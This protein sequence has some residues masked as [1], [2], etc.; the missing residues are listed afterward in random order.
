MTQS[1]QPA[2]KLPGSFGQPFIGEASAL[3][4]QQELFYWQRFQRYAGPFKTRIMSRKVAIL[5]GPEANQLVLKDE[6]DKFSSRLG[7][8]ILEP[9]LGEGLLL[10]DGEK[11]ARTRKLMYPAFHG[12]ALPHYFDLV[13]NTVENFLDGGENR[14]PILVIEEFRHLTLLIACRLLLGAG[15]DGEVKQLVSYFSE[16]VAGIRTIVRWNIPFTKF[17]RALRARWKLEAFLRSIIEQ[18]RSQAH[19]G[20]DILGLLLGATDE[21][22]NKLSDPEIIAQILNLL[23]A[24]H[25]TTAKLVT[26]TLFELS[27]HP[28]WLEKLR[29]EQTEVLQGNFLTF[30][31]LK[32]LRQMGYV[33]KE[34]E[35]L[36]PPIYSIPRGV[37]EDVEY[38]GYLIPQGWYV[39]L[40]PLLTHRLSELYSEPNC[41]DPSRFAPPREED[42]RHPFA[43]I[44][45]GGGTHKCLGRELASLEVKI[46]LSIL[47]RRYQW[48]FTIDRSTVM[49]V[50]QANKIERQM[51]AKVVKIR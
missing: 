10:Q 11:H 7:W 9:L 17:G 14:G 18:R 47:L 49:P 27:F 3:F 15:A 23:F 50:C 16:I 39:V 43:L 40:S 45:F 6:A 38:G 22:G 13:H 26:W 2:D 35:R 48:S 29:Q 37:I 1:I 30:S 46:I 20:R 5:V 4:R 51:W 12:A 8:S 24:A 36:H 34:I 21:A 19:E 32:H 33:L 41:F 31:H 42:T 25:E 44:G 28:Q